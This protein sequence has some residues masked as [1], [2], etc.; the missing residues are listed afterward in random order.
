MTLAAK[1]TAPKVNTRLNKPKVKI[2]IGSVI[3]L[4][5][6]NTIEFKMLKIITKKA[7]PEISLTSKFG[8]IRDNTKTA[9]TLITK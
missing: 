6:G 3:I 1:A 9:K 5:I 4:T 2:V 7:A 8:T